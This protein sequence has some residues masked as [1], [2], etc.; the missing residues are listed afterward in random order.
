MSSKNILFIIYVLII[1]S[2]SGLVGKRPP[3]ALPW[4]A[5]MGKEVVGSGYVFQVC[6]LKAY[7]GHSA[8]NN[9]GVV[10]HKALL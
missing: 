6:C 1:F 5:A 8:N 7:V 10:V 2:C 9:V 3:R 4:M